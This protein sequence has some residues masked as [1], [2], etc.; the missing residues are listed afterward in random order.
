M[1]ESILY[2]K[3]IL[4]ENDTIVIGVS[5]GPDSMCLLSFL[6]KTVIDINLNIIVAHVNHNVRKEAAS[7]EEFVKN[8]TINNGYIFE[9]IKLPKI[10][11]NFESKTRRLRYD[12]F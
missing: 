2:L 12:F 6:N 1:R 5:G 4:K 11:G 10:T 3:S 7:E 9:S 8:Y